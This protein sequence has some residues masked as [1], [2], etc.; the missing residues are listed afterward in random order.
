M[1]PQR[2]PAKPEVEGNDGHLT[3]FA[4]E[5]G[6]RWLDPIPPD[7]YLS[8]MHESNSPYWRVL[9]AILATTIAVGCRSAFS[10]DAR[11]K[12]LLS[13]EDIANGVGLPGWWEKMD[14]GNARRALR[15]LKADHRVRTDAEGRLWLA[16][17]FKLPAG[18]QG[19]PNPGES[20]KRSV[21]D[22]FKPYY[23]RQIMKLKPHIIRELVAAKEARIEKSRFRYA[24]M[25]HAGR[26]IDDREDNTIMARYGVNLIRETH[27]LAPDKKAAIDARRARAEA[28]IPMIEKHVQTFYPEVCHKPKNAVSQTVLNGHASAA[29][30]AKNG[31]S[32][33]VPRVL[34]EYTERDRAASV[35]GSE[36]D[37]KKR[38]VCLPVPQTDRPS[39]L[40]SNQKTEELRA[41]LI[42]WLGAKLPDE[43]PGLKLLDEILAALEPA[44]LSDLTRR[45]QKR[46]NSITSYGMVL[47]LARD[48]AVAARTPKTETSEPKPLTPA[49]KFAEE[50]AKRKSGTVTA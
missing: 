9:G 12:K 21:T 16:G 30:A 41:M 35:G 3:K 38:E 11:T 43:V 23:V 10:I 2:K 7:H 29:S 48:C 5:L 18:P 28:L 36:I 4:G 25:V 1:I 13:I 6:A 33:L 45:I 22:L 14:D 40:L 19:V 27:E 47:G 44:S 39:S 20:L 34:T 49:E 8:L 31:T 50:Y 24:D 37:L 32:E 26:L 46:Q 17:D 42:R 15:E